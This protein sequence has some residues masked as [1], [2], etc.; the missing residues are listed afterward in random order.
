[1]FPLQ[2]FCAAAP[3]RVAHF[4]ARMLPALRALI[5]QARIAALVVTLQTSGGPATDGRTDGPAS[6]RA[7][8]RTTL[9][10]VVRMAFLLT[11]RGARHRAE[12]RAPAEHGPCRPRVRDGERHANTHATRGERST[13]DSARVPRS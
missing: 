3:D 11:A 4:P 10:T 8:H 6:S 9:E 2:S 5:S 13:Q 7:Y 1:A 12:R